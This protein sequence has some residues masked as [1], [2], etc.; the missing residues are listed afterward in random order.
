LNRLR[1]HGLEK[2]PNRLHGGRG[3]KTTLLLHAAE[4]ERKEHRVQQERPQ[5]RDVNRAALQDAQLS[6]ERFQNTR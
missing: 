6:T 1:D 3:W 4:R 2:S 5:R